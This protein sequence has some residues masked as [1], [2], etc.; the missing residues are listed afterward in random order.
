MNSKLN[1]KYAIIHC[2]S[3]WFIFINTI[4]ISK[5]CLEVQNQINEYIYFKKEGL[6][7]FFTQ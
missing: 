3:K 5:D 2:T 4:L 1:S 6:L 7:D